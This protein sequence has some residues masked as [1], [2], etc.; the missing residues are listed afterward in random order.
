VFEFVEQGKDGYISSL[1]ELP[2]KLLDL[3]NHP[4]KLASIRN[5]QVLLVSNDTILEQLTNLIA[6]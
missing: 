5:N 2:Q 6:L 1:D 4:D 3:A